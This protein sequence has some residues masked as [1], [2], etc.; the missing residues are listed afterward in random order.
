MEMEAHVKKSFRLA[1]SLLVCALMACSGNNATNNGN[2]GNGE[3]NNS[4]SDAGNNTEEDVD[5]SGVEYADEYETRFDTLEFGNQPAAK[6]N[7]L[8]SNSLDQSIEFPIIVLLQFTD[9][10]TEAGT[11]M[12]E[13]GA[14]LKTD[15]EG[16]YEWDPDSEAEGTEGTIE[17]ASGNFEAQIDYFGF[18]ATFRFEDEVNKTII[19]INALDISGQLALEDDGA[20]ARVANGEMSGYVTKEDGDSTEIALTPGSDPITLTQ[21]FGA[22]AL[23]YDSTTGE[24]TELGA[25]NADSW[26]VT[27]TYTAVP[28]DIDD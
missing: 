5:N 15:T 28:A 11:L 16:T 6:L 9:F 20:T 25:E 27:G 2:N 13:G 1:L 14:G 3:T 18:V 26:Y 10:D 7:M 4:G 23:N 21:I 19:P 8:V 12:L 22:D 17:P 24:E